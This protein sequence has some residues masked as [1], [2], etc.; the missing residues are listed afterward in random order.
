MFSIYFNQCGGEKKK[1]KQ[2]KKLDSVAKRTVCKG[3]SDFAKI[4]I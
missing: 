1:K 4:F 2:T 3:I